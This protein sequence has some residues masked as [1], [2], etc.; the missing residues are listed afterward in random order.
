MGSGTRMG[1]SRLAV[2]QVCRDG[3][4]SGRIDESPGSFLAPHHIETQHGAKAFL[5]P[6]GQ[7]MLWMTGKASVVNLLD[8]RLLLQPLGQCQS[9]GAMG[10]HAQ[11]Q[12]FQTLEK[13]PSVERAQSWACSAQ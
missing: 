12:G 4:Q 8:T 7:F 1:N 3:N 9:A 13:N 2:T 5:L 11:T 10:L 6:L